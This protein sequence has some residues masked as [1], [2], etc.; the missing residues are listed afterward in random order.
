[1]HVI[2]YLFEEKNAR[3]KRRSLCCVRFCF[4]ESFI[5]PLFLH[6]VAGGGVPCSPILVHVF[7]ILIL[8]NKVFSLLKKKKKKVQFLRLSILD[9]PIELIHDYLMSFIPTSFN[10]YIYS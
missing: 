2:F 1:M 10:L 3:Y 9:F 7:L 5:G 6:F 8:S 4:V